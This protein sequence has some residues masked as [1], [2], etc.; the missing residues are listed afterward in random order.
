MY[1]KTNDTWSAL[2]VFTDNIT[3]GDDKY[4]LFTFIPFYVEYTFRIY[5][6]QTDKL[7]LYTVVQFIIEGF[8]VR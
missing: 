5:V 7:L 1:W 2:N 4:P 3:F 6:C 8:T